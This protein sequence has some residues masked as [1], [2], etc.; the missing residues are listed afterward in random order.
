MGIAQCIDADWV[1]F[2]ANKMKVSLFFCFPGGNEADGD[3]RRQST[4]I[5]WDMNIKRGT[6]LGYS[7]ALGATAYTS[8]FS[9]TAQTGPNPKSPE[10]AACN[11]SGLQLSPGGLRPFRGVLWTGSIANATEAMTL[12]R[13][14]RWY[15]AER[16][17]YLQL[18]Q[19]GLYYSRMMANFFRR[20][21]LCSSGDYPGTL[22]SILSGEGFDERKLG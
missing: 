4:R 22:S 1:Y 8:P 10:L 7:A 21:I 14:R 19:V 6:L 3:Q 18:P 9:I 17:Y 11:P 5:Q 16:H 15:V 13:Q 12:S 20:S 2:R